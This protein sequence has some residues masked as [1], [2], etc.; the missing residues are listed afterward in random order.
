MLITFAAAVTERTTWYPLTL[1]WLVI[2]ASVGLF[3]GS[4]YLILATNVGARLGFLLVGAVTAGFL[5]VLSM[6]WITTATPLNVFKGRTVEFKA[7]AVVDNVESSNIKEVQRILEDG[8]K[9][10]GTEFSN[11]KA[12]ADTVLGPAVDGKEKPASVANDLP[13]VP[14][15]VTDIYQIGGS[16]PNPLFLEFTHTPEYAAAFFCPVDQVKLETAFRTTCDT[17]SAAAANN[18]ILILQKDL[19][20]LRQPPIFLFFGSTA[21][22]ILFLLALHWRE[23]DLKENSDEEEP[24]SED[25]DKKEK[26]DA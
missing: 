21:L 12:A 22:F 7:V 26:V 16:Q 4:T 8:N 17:S 10:S 20:S 11:I 9:L 13:S 3:F 18:R 14:V 23:K 25:E 19:G 6:L 24:D 1:G 5:M 2:I 15:I